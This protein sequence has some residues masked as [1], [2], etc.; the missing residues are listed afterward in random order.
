M[1]L[2]INYKNQKVRK[3]SPGAENWE[4]LKTLMKGGEKKRLKMK[5]EKKKLII[6]GGEQ[7]SKQNGEGGAGG[8]G[9]K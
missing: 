3:E 4:K 6:G 1:S 8:C 2:V 5:N 9:A 7:K